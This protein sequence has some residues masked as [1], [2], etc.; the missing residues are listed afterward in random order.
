[1]MDM[2][3]TPIKQS[4]RRRA[5]HALIKL[6][7]EHSKWLRT[8]DDDGN[9]VSMAPEQLRDTA[10]SNPR[11]L[12]YEWRLISPLDL[13]AEA[14]ETLHHAHS[15]FQATNAAVRAWYDWRREHDAAKDRERQNAQP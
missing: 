3:P 15:K 5:L 14:A 1:M 2:V 11:Y 12:D 8:V 10:P 9:T 13:I 7:D 6:A 4:S